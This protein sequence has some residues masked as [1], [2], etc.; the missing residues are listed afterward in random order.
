MAV[1]APTKQADTSRNVEVW[2]GGASTED[3]E[4]VLEIDARGF[5]EFT[6]GSSAGAVDVFAS[7][8]GSAFLATAIGV[9]SAVD[10]LPDALTTPGGVFSVQGTFHRLRFMQNGATD[11]AGFALVAKRAVK[12]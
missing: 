12:G 2:S 6:F 10:I 1:T 9:V 3:N 5:E 4:V 7:L 11:V 8:D